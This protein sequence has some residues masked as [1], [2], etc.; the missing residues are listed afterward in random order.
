MTNPTYDL[1]Y[2]VGNEWQQFANSTGQ[3]YYYN[4]RT[5]VT[6]FPVPTGFEDTG[7]VCAILSLRNI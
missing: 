4:H 3:D 2:L 7:I 6:Q 1:G 5:R